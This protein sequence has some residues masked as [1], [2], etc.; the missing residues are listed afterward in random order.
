MFCS[1]FNLKNLLQ[2]ELRQLK[3]PNQLF[4]CGLVVIQINDGV[5]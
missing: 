3:E 2:G 1:E 5:T 4:S